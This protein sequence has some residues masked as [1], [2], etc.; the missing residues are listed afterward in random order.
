[1]TKLATRATTA[2]VV[3]ENWYLVKK[4]ELE[5][6]E[7]LFDVVA[8]SK[9]HCVFVCKSYQGCRVAS[10]DAVSGSCVGKVE[11]MDGESETTPTLFI[12][13]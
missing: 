3:P 4:S 5:V 13:N 10:Y 7:V 1:M 2:K 8:K 6:E 11:E 12:V 9:M